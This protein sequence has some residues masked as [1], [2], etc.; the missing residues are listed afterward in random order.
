MPDV[1]C[2]RVV[3]PTHLVLTETRRGSG[4]MQADLVWCWEAAC[5]GHGPG[6]S[7]GTPGG[8]RGE[9]ERG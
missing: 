1:P 9:A 6:A 5:V 4:S 3:A 7:A 2:P 8:Q